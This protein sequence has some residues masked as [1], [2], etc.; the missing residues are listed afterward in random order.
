[1][2]VADVVVICIVI[3]RDATGRSKYSSPSFSLEYSTDV[4][5]T[6]FYCW[7]ER[8]DV[9]AAKFLFLLW[10]RQL[11]FK[12]YHRIIQLF[13]LL[14]LYILF[15]YRIMQKKNRDRKKQEIHWVIFTVM[16]QWVLKTYPF[17]VKW[18]IIY[19]RGTGT[20]SSNVTVNLPPGTIINMLLTHVSNASRISSV[21]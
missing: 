12:V 13:K 20:S 5:L 7:K 16:V 8:T 6:A 19:I 10:S 3:L 9:K 14:G 17:Q 4:G 21:Q 15:T 18:S 2:D 11:Q 1:M